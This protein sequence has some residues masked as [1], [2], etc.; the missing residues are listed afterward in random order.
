[1][2]YSA[3]LKWYQLS[4]ITEVIGENPVDRF[5]AFKNEQLD[6]KPK[7][8]LQMNFPNPSKQTIIP[9]QDESLSF[10]AKAQSLSKEAASLIELKDK[11]SSFDGCSLKKTA[12]NTFIGIGKEK[13]PTVFCVFDAPKAPAERTGHL[14]EG[15]QGVLLQKMLSAI[16]LSPENSYIAPLI[17]WRLPGDRKPSLVEEKICTPFIQRALELTNPDFILIFG[18]IPTRA[19][20]GIESISKARQNVQKITI[21]NKEIQVISTF[22]PD[23]VS[24]SQTSRKNAWDDLKKLAQLIQNKASNN[25]EDK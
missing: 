14:F 19:L 23:M 10:V 9:P 1:M 6:S 3:I 24:A 4:G 22:G 8:A 20:L 25:E 5:L 17:P 7:K 12:I 16:K 21:N 13:N 15:P 2:N 11:I 18:A